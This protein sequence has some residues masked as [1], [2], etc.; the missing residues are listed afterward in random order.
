EDA[1]ADRLG[2]AQTQPDRAL[3]ILQRPVAPEMER[4]QVRIDQL[5]LR[6]EL[7]AHELRSRLDVHIEQ[8][9]ER[10]DI[11]DVLE[12]LT[13]ARVGVLA[14]A[15]RGQRHADHRDVLAELGLR[16]RFGGI[17][18]QVSAR[19][20]PRHVLVPGLR[21]HRHHEIGA[22]AR[23]KV[24]GLRDAPLVPSRQALDVGREDVAGR[25]GDAHTQHRAREQLVG[26]GGARAVDVGEPDDEVVYA[27]DRAATWHLSF[28]WV[29]SMR[30]FCMSQAQIR[31]AQVY[32]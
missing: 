29:R 25:N 8:R 12:Q 9:T 17:V 14:V 10:S 15:N 1:L 31:R 21:V 4:V 22:P 24:A 11:H 7:L 5:F 30:Y 32:L 16:H 3:Q 6:L 26:A 28:A 20:D 27:A 13:L 23:P 18:E 19:L 2:T